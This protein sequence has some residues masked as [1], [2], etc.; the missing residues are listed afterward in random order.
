MA[1]SHRRRGRDCLVG[2][3]NRPLEE[4]SNK[5]AQ[6]F[7]GCRADIVPWFGSSALC[8]SGQVAR[9]HMPSDCGRQIG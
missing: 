9:T 6:R 5:V 1:C 2:G 8:D 4:L 7:S 3:V